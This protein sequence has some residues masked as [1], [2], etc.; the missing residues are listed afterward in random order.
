M[1]LPST[2]SSTQETNWCEFPLLLRFL[3][4]RNRRENGVKSKEA[5]VNKEKAKTLLT[6]VVMTSVASNHLRRDNF[7]EGLAAAI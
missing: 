7:T 2:V 3:S 6:V 5:K 4:L 1:S